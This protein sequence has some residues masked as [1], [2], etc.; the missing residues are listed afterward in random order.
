[1]LK[2]PSRLG[3]EIELT[4]QPSYESIA[5]MSERECKDRGVCETPDYYTFRRLAAK[6]VYERFRALQWRSPVLDGGGVEFILAPFSVKDIFK[7]RGTL[8]RMLSFV[9]SFDL[10]PSTKDG[11]HVN[12]DYS[13]LGATLREQKET[14]KRFLYFV[15]PLSSAYA[16]MQKFAGREH[17]ASKHSDVYFMLKDPFRKLSHEE[18]SATFKGIEKDILDCLGD[19][20]MCSLNMCFGKENRQ[21]IE[22]RWFSSTVSTSRILKICIFVE[23]IFSYCRVTP[24]PTLRGFKLFTL[25]KYWWQILRLWPYD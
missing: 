12:V 9:R 11:I 17:E 6:L 8:S 20:E 10:Y 13:L 25:K 14:L 22:W 1:M 2:G 7:L 23:S 15:S 4:Y 21:C 19:R 3:L 24:N 16:Y 18:L 5:R